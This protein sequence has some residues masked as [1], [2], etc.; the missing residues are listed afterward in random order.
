MQ[1]L[2]AIL[3]GGSAHEIV[4][5]LRSGQVSMPIV[6]KFVLVVILAAT[7]FHPA[8]GHEGATGIVKERM[9]L[10]ARNQAN[11]KA[12]GVH[13]RQGDLA[14]SVPLT[15]EIR[16]W[17]ERMAEYFPEG[18]GGKPSEAAPAIWADFVGF[19]NAAMANRLAADALVKAA[20]AGDAGE[21]VKAFKSLA[22]TCKSCH[23]SYRVQ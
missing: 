11:L 14:A 13:L 20:E 4:V 3:T 1:G 5:L 6:L 15:V 16:D 21:A 22:A 9:D 10:F 17:A 7:G 2:P 19:T 23:R 12:I 18:S 8:L